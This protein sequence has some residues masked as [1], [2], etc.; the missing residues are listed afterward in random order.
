MYLQHII[1]L[2]F[3]V[4]E[5]ETKIFFVFPIEARKVFAKQAAEV[6]LKGQTPPSSLATPT[7]LS[8]MMESIGQAFDLPLIDGGSPIVEQAISCYKKWLLEELFKPPP[9]LNDEQYFYKKC[10]RHMSLLFRPRGPKLENSNHV[11]LCIEVINI[12]DEASKVLKDVLTVASWEE[13]L[14]IFLGICDSLLKIQFGEVVLADKLQ[15]SLLRVLFALWMRSTTQNTE[16]WT[17]FKKLFQTWRHRL[18]TIKQWN[19]TL[20][21]LGQRLFDILYGPNYGTKSVTYSIE[22]VDTTLDLEDNH[23]FYCFYR[24]LHLVGDLE[25]LISP[26]NYHEAMKGIA[27]L[28]KSFIQ[29]EPKIKEDKETKAIP[30][31]GNTIL[32]IVAPFLLEAL[33]SY[34]DGFEFGKAEALETACVLFVS[35]IPTTEFHTTYLAMFYRGL[36]EA[37]KSNNN[38]LLSVVLINSTNLF[39]CHFRGIRVLIPSFIAAIEK[40]LI[41][42]D[43][44]PGIVS[45]R[46]ILKKV[47]IKILSGMLCFANHFGET[48]FKTNSPFQLELT[49]L[50][51]LNSYKDL[52]DHISHIFLQSIQSLEDVETKQLLLCSVY[53]YIMEHLDKTDTSSVNFVTQMVASILSKLSSQAW[54]LPVVI[55]ALNF[56]IDLSTFAKMIP[57]YET[58]SKDIIKDLCNI[59]LNCCDTKKS[60]TAP[61]PELV[62]GCLFAIYCW[63][64]NGQFILVDRSLLEL[65][66]NVLEVT[67]YGALGSDNSYHPV[68]PKIENAGKYVLSNLVIRMGLY[69][70]PSSHS[71]FEKEKDIIERENLSSKNISYCIFDDEL[72]SIIRYPRV[73]NNIKITLLIRNVAGRFAWNLSLNYFPEDYVKVVPPKPENEQYI[74]KISEQVPKSEEFLKILTDFFDE[75]EERAH[76][77]ILNETTAREKKQSKMLAE[78][79][80][81]LNTNVSIERT[82]PPP[83]NAK[84]YDTLAMRIF[85][86]SFG[87]SSLSNKGRIRFLREKEMD[88]YLKFIDKVDSTPERECVDIG[89]VYIPNKS[90]ERISENEIFSVQGGSPA[91]IHFINSIGWEINLENHLGFKGGLD[92]KV[93]G[94]LTRYYSDLNVEIVFYICSLMPN[95]EEP[96][97]HKK[98]LINKTRV[99]ITWVENINKYEPSVIDTDNFANIVIHPLINGL[100]LI[101]IFKKQINQLFGPLLD[102][103]IVSKHILGAAVRQ[104]ALSATRASI[105]GNDPWC[106]GQAALP[107]F[108]QINNV[109]NSYRQQTNSFN[110]IFGDQFKKIKI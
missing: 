21:G 89:I 93:N 29:L 40:V 18:Q 74:P 11:E 72:I 17:T 83:Y 13:L 104:T 46:T 35:K 99:M 6:L 92:P 62:T 95:K 31:N 100:F 94:T 87:F 102:E 22:G 16:L 105:S 69:T 106:Y 84:L 108:Q 19:S 34:K 37:L 39:L 76:S 4:P 57:L 49:E 20:F 24:V 91:Y 80:Y 14:K 61:T 36:E 47:C 101:R 5:N 41:F 53:I 68:N 97:S 25:Q 9:L 110:E 64:S 38:H 30:P 23:V 78:R 26:Q 60:K 82:E 96:Q 86:S 55:S 28:T 27:K 48:S 43:D 90:G 8:T 51:Q 107:R 56:F 81:N 75:A 2:E 77:K 44:L 71:S 73:D 52:N 50:P 85:L 79:E 65:V 109:V 33:I 42:P 70:D 10:F 54:P 12:Y 63:A 103:M 88:A 15:V 3:L 45:N 59:V 7:H 32:H 1:D 98:E 67:I 66:F 58:M